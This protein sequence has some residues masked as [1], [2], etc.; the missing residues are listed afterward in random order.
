[1]G[2]CVHKNIS[3]EKVHAKGIEKKVSLFKFHVTFQVS[4]LL[5]VV[6]NVNYLWISYLS[7]V[8]FGCLSDLQ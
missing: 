2:F 1:M 5:K 6:I 3:E 8:I 7:F 4:V